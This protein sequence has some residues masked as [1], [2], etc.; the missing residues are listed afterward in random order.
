MNLGDRFSTTRV[1][2]NE[3][4]V[5]GV[6]YVV[7]VPQ[8]DADGN[9]VGGVALPEVSVPLGTFT[10]WNQS[11]PP[12]TGLRYLAGL[13]GSFE[14]FARTRVERERAG[15]PRPSLEE[16]YQ[17]REDYLTRV[18]QAAAGLVRERFLRAEDLDQVVRQADATWTAL[19]P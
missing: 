19:A 12:I 9:D 18:R 11:E 5:L 17:G 10:G 4:P 16:R 14:P 6:P 8:A 15:D 7:L 2:T 1:I 3:P 13:V